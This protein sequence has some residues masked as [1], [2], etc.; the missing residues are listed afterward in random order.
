MT[1]TAKALPIKDKTNW[2]IFWSTFFAK[3]GENVLDMVVT[4]STVGILLAY[5]LTTQ[6]LAFFEYGGFIIWIYF[7][8]LALRIVQDFDESYTNDELGKQ[9]E[10][11]KDIVKEIHIIERHE[12]TMS[13]EEL[14]SRL[15][16]R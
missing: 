11:I 14:D 16:M 9:L 12:S 10:D 8:L 6:P 7:C 5:L 3:V 2:K 4:V 13:D 15:R 1:T